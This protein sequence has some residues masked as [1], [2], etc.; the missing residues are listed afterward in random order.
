[1]ITGANNYG[2]VGGGMGGIPPVG[3]PPMG[4]MGMPPMGPMGGLGGI[5][6][7]GSMGGFGQ[8]S[9][10]GSTRPFWLLNINSTIISFI[11]ISKLM[12]YI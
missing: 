6:P 12:P 9:P 1:M 2:S 4:G 3:M 11:K 10:Y 5:G 7:M 8:S